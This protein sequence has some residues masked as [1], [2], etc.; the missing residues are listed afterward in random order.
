MLSQ[1]VGMD[2][3]DVFWAK[4]Q[5]MA[6]NLSSWLCSQTPLFFCL[7]YWFAPATLL[8]SITHMLT[9]DHF[10]C[11][12]FPCGTYLLRVY[13]A[14]GRYFDVS[15]LWFT[16]VAWGV[17]SGKVPKGPDCLCYA[18]DQQTHVKKTIFQRLWNNPQLDA[19]ILYIILQILYYI[20]LH[21]IILYYIT[22]YY[23]IL[24]YI[25]L[26]YIIL[27]YII[28]YY[29]ILYIVI[30]YYSIFYCIILYY[31]PGISKKYILLTG[32]RNETI[33]YHYSPSGQLNLSIFNLDS[34][35]LYVEIVHQRKD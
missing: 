24:Y 8:A 5:G 30:I 13:T 4:V 26:H 19:S 33:R 22:L 7:F 20:T 15:I 10:N 21:Y 1:T 12:I 3:G 25:I 17:S 9:L 6:S 31:I 14:H 2:S 35:T 32:N 29:I 11:F 27:H 23:I 34:H 16:T 18:T 28:L